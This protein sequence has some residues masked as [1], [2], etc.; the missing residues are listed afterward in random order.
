MPK[1]NT[2]NSIAVDDFDDVLGAP[3]ASDDTSSRALL[4]PESDLAAFWGTSTRQVR[5]LLSDGTISKA[6]PGIYDA[7]D[8]TRRY[9][10]K[11]IFSASRRSTAAPELQA[12][13]LRLAK[14]QADKLEIANAAARGEL[15][16][17]SS[18]KSAWA[19]VLRDV[20]ASMLAVPS[21]VTQRLPHLSTHDLEVI[22]REIRDALSETAQ[23]GNA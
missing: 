15:V 20:R 7:A 17:V 21:R 8:C 3:L 16:S 19:D 18:V 2:G 14:E 22:D 9:M 1:S 11:L 10:Q 6:E 5:M 4:M 23:N 12:E 13:K